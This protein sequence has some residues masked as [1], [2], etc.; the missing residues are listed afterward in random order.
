MLR[1]LF[2]LLAFTLPA[3]PQWRTGYFMQGEAG[4]Q[5]AATIP[6]AKYTHV[7]HYGV[8]PTYINSVCGLTAG[9]D[10]AGFVNGA[11]AA[12]VKAILGIV[13]DDTREAIS[14]CTTPW[15][16]PQFVDTIGNFVA[17][18]HYDGVD[19]DWANGIIAPQFQDLVGRLRTAMP[20]ATLSVTVGV[21]ERFM[22]A[23]V[24]ND[25]DQIHIRAYDLD[26]TD[27]SGSAIAYTWYHSATLQGANTQDQAM[28][29]LAWYYVSAGNAPSKLGIVVPFYGR[30]R[31]GCLDSTGIAGVTDPNQTWVAGAGVA[32]IAYRDLVN[33]TYWSLGTQVWD[34]SRKSQYIQYRSGSCSTDAFIS[35]VGP[36]QLQEIA[37]L[38]KTNGLGGI[39]TYGLPFEY[40]S[41]QDGDARYPLSNAMYDA[42][43]ATASAPAISPLAR[44]STTLSRATFPTRRTSNSRTR[45]TPPSI[46]TS[47]PLPSALTGGAYSRSLVAAGT[48]PLTWAVTSGMLPAG[49]TLGSSTGTIGGTPTAPGVF[50]LTVRATNAAGSNSKQLSLTVNTAP[51]PPSIATS[52]PLPDALTG[53]AYSQTLMAASTTPITWAVT[54]GTLPAGLSLGTSTGIISGTPTAAGV[55]TL[56][57]SATN[58]VGS[59]SKQLS[60]TVNAAPTSPSIATSSP[61]PTAVTGAAYS[62]A[63]MAAGTT[64]ITWAV[65]GGTLPAGLSLGAST[66]ILSGTPTAAGVSTL[67]VSATNAVGSNSKQLSL[68]VNAAPTP[69]SIATSS[70]VPS[71][72]T[73]AAYSQALV[74]TGTTPITWAVTSG[75]LPAGL[76]LG[77]STGSISGTPTAA[78]VSTLTVGAT[79]AV[80]SD[81]RQL[82]LTVNAAPTPPSIATSSP[83]PSALTGAAYS[84]TLVAGGTTPITWAV[85]SG[86]LPAGLSLGAST[87]LLSGTPTAAGVFTLTAGATNAVGSNSKQLSLTVNAAPT[88]PSIATS[89]PLPSAVTGTLYSLTLT[90]AGT[91][92]ITWAVTSGTLPAG[93]SLGSSSGILSGTPTAAGVFTLTVSATNAVGSDSKQLSLTVNAAPTPPSIATSSPLPSAVTGTAYS[94]TLMAGGTTPITWAVT[95]GTLPAGLTLGAST[96]ILSGTPT[97]AGV[98][99]LTVSATNAVGSNSK[100]LSLTVNAAPTSPSIVTSSPL[101]DALT[102]AAYSQTLVA[103]GTTPI[104]W[105]VTSGTLPA[106]L[107]LGS[108]T[109]IVSGTPTA[110]GVSTLTVGATN[111]VGSDSKQLSLTVNAAATVAV[112][113]SPA[114]AALTTSQTRLFTATVT[115]TGNTAV[116]WSLSPVVGSI[117]SAG[118]YTAPALIASSQTV[119]VT[120]TS[121]A[122]PTKSAAATATFSPPVTVSLTPSSVS[123]LPSQNQTFTATVSGTSNTALTWSINPALGSLVSGATTAVYVAPSTAPSTQSVTITATSMA[124]ASKTTTAAITLLQ[125]VTVFL[126][127]STVSL[128][129]SGTQQFTATLL[130]ANNTA[131]TWSINPSVGTISSAGLYTAPSSIQT[132]Q[133]VAVTAQS[134]AQPTQSASGVVSLQTTPVLNQWSMGYYNSYDPTSGFYLPVSA[135]QW[136]GLTHVIQVGTLVNA[137]GTLD[138][139]T[140]KFSTNAASLVAAAHANQVKAIVCLKAAVE[141]NFNSAAGDHLSTFVSSVMTLVD[142]YGFDGV[143]LDWEPFTVA[144]SGAHMT[145]LSAALRTALGSK[146]LTV[147]APAQTQGY[148]YWGANH[149][150]FDRVNLMTYDMNGYDWDGY[151]WFNSPIYGNSVYSIES[152]TGHFLAEGLPA[153]KMGIGIP[154]YGIRWTGG[155]LDSDNNQGISG[156]RQ[157]W[158]SGNAPTQQSLYYSSLISLITT[159]EYHWDSEAVVPYLSHVG[160]TPA[161]YW[162]ITYDDPQSIQAK[163]QYIIARGLGGW[164]IWELGADWISGAAHPHPL[165]DAVQAGSA[166]AILSASALDSGAVGT[167]YS[168]SLSAT[169]AAPLHWALSS[170]SLPNGLSLSSVGV[171]SG[172]PTTAGTFG[173]IVTVGNFAG[174]TL[175]SFTI[176]IAASTTR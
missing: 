66:G 67:T 95:S 5:T 31:K 11:H 90:A 172:T 151:P 23:A 65:T 93:F 84:Q 165:L 124:D 27:L 79:N 72:E 114:S 158:K 128:A 8:Q 111:A 154:F 1:V 127:P 83:L 103:G 57:V 156:P 61:L 149:G 168:A 24:Q 48:T 47:S 138:L 144:T 21:A 10:I 7:V 89:S 139:T 164:I 75:T 87:G 134:V 105:A 80:G 118:L 40:S 115:N 38:V 109:G 37:A 53:A 51:T 30:I 62:Q 147:A 77:S 74:A 112:S 6:W 39:A 45:Q 52:S 101:P 125:A 15:N 34:D 137:D 145:A 70:P 92:P 91:T 94:Q 14:A 43:V 82:S 12:G 85:T 99:T 41:T 100:Q 157:M 78:G 116:T 81:A 163:V 117:T 136:G 106:G 120:A 108:S 169:G 56:T 161:T 60:L 3:L 55:S 159:Q 49:L 133:T 143:D 44:L 73:G 64:P 18:N 142:T 131:V 167:V 71:A 69:P 29:I 150:S 153:A 63:L 13:E 22:T 54:G 175:Q 155:I 36:E 25:L 146:I 135:I 140:Y 98:S 129:P 141:A 104:T 119:T 76:S 17:N 35:F 121:V 174:S 86:M 20:T 171:I 58:A 166:P 148:V 96:G 176:A 152:F 102:G 122:D 107:S 126:S 88:P 59:N 68:T 9:T 42:M 123:L 4:G 19:I 50:T 26:S 130:G 113:V 46:V 2:C 132:S 32:S 173:F 160:T 16:I 33:S 110:A 170:G 162:Y 97:A 28:D